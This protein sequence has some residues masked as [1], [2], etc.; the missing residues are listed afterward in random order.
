MVR[1]TAPALLTTGDEVA[2]ARAIEVG[3]V[4]G[5]ALVHAWRTDATRAELQRLVAEGRQAQDRFL[6]ANLR[7]VA[8]LAGHAAHRSGMDFDELFQEGCVALGRAVQR[9]DPRRGR[10]STY[11]FPVVGQHLVRVTSSLAGQLGV[12]HGRAV[13]QRR[14]QGLADRLAQELGRTAG[15]DEISEALGRDRSWTARLLHQRPPLPLD[16]LAEVPAAAPDADGREDRLVLQQLG[17]AVLRLPHD[18]RAVLELR[19]G[20]ADGRCHSYREV[21]RRLG[22]SAASARRV[23]QRALATLRSRRAAPEQGARPAEG[24]LSRR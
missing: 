13:A 22:I 23:E 5:H 21:G 1:F 6:L 16:A 9:F 17:P 4:A 10:F 12:P 7:M 11:A 8:L 20:F 2:L 18:Q 15:L 14:A 3:V 19:F 24:R